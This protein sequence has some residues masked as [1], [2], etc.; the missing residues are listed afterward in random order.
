MLQ[1]FDL[2]FS[3]DPRVGSL[4]D[5]VDVS[6]NPGDKVA[7]VG[8]NGAGKSLLLRILAGRLNPSTGR[9]VL[10]RGLSLAYLPQDFDFGFHGVLGELLARDC[11]D[12]S[13]HATAK[14]IHRLGL[15][16]ATQGQV[17]STLS[18]GEKMR[19]ALAA[20]LAT[21]PDFLLLDEPTNHLDALTKEWLERFLRE[22]SEGV[23]IACHD[24]SVIN[25]IADRV[26]E[27]DR[28][29][30][31]EYAGG[32]DDMVAAKR[33]RDALQQ[34]TWERHRDEDRRLRISAEAASQRAAKMT[35]KPTTRTYD[36]K[37]KAFYA[38]K[39]ARMDKRAKAIRSRVQKG[40][41]A[42]P[43]KPIVQ[44]SLAL[45]F[46]CRPMRS[47]EA[48]TARGLGKRFGARVLFERLNLTLNR[49]S[50]VAVVGP[51]GCGKNTLFRILMREE[52]ADTGEIHWAPGV[53]IAVLSQERDALEMTQPAIKA[54]APGDAAAA[55][56]ARTA[57][58]GLG[59]RGDMAERPV[60]VLSVGERT[61]VEIVAMLLSGANVLLLDEP[62]NHLDLASVEA[63]ELALAEFP[64]SILF[65]SHDREF[66]RR[67]A[68]DVVVLGE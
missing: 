34:E 55:Q 9:V 48:L 50:R 36:P 31:A 32:F 68:T 61:K 60:G 13:P 33:K 11:P 16:P 46:P 40:R 54:L 67:L 2:S 10:T 65:T 66:V 14:A 1:A 38:G 4:F 52:A 3:P 53:Q 17:Y 28:G 26:L 58:A 42:A 47:P 59:L 23:L 57:L 43:D 8:R 19:G 49:G 63:L 37:S 41:E 18:L 12:A 35:R 27:L 20:L 56:F 5:H 45:E 21:E 51:N 7:L 39:E 22:S 15:S 24:R 64:G 30:M 6:L 44:D 25:A 62:T 29:T